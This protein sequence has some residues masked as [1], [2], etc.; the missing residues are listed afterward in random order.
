MKSQIA[1]LGIGIVV[2]TGVAYVELKPAPS[3][4]ITTV[5]STPEPASVVSKSP[6][7]NPVATPIK[8]KSTISK[9]TI[10]GGDDEDDEDENRRHY[11]DDDEEE[12]DD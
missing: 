12:D 10:S 11:D 4:P 3:D 6:I 1:L 7:S 8:S 9:P 5:T 2:A